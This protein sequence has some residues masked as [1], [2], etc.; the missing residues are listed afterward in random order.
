MDKNVNKFLLK[1]YVFM[2]TFYYFKRIERAAKVN[3][4]L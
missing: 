3:I 2:K 4:D 1:S